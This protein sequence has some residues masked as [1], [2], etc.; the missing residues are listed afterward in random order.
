MKDIIEKMQIDWNTDSGLKWISM[1]ICKMI[2]LSSGEEE[3]EK[4]RTTQIFMVR[5][6]SA[7]CTF[8]GEERDTRHHYEYE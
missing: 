8:A 6:K 5:K 2:E 4:G 7:V 1:W 3:E